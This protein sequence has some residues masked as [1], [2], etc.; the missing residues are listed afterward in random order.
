MSFDY[1]PSPQGCIRCVPTFRF[2]A[3]FSS[4]SLPLSFPWI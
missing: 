2:P 4:F 3:S 1:V